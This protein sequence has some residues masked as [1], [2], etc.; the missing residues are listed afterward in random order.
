[1]SQH[2][3]KLSGWRWLRVRRAMLERDDYKCRSCGRWGNEI[4]HI[5]PLQS[6][7]APYDPENL[8]CLCTG[9]HVRKTGRERRRSLSPAAAEWR[10]LIDGI[11][12]AGRKNASLSIRRERRG[13]DR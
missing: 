5:K 1:M 2:H 8:Q 12:T 13:L 4:D 3:R 6:G 9:C 10:E 7:G 11:P